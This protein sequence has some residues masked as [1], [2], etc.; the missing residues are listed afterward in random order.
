MPLYLFYI[1]VALKLV[2]K[3]IRTIQCTFLYEGDKNHFK[4]PLVKLDKVCSP[5]SIRGLVLHDTGKAMKLL[6]PKLGGIGW[7]KIQILGP[8]FGTKNMPIIRTRKRSF[9]SISLSLGPSF[10]MQQIFKKIWFSN[11][12]CGKFEMVPLPTSR[13]ILCG[14]FLP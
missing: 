14:R 2:L 13:W 4:W 1:C 3:Y 5:K 12:V 6:V 8:N 11:T 7:P 10:G 9:V